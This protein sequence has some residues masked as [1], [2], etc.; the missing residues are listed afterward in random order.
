VLQPTDV[1]FLHL[2]WAQL[3][4]GDAAAAKSSLEAGLRRGLSAAKLSPDERARLKDLE[5]TLGVTAP[6]VEPAVEPE[7]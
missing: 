6:K 7:S 5:T 3:K 4:A 2:A 1:K